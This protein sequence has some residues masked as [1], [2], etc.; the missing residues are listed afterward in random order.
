MKSVFH[1]FG[2]VDLMTLIIC[3]PI[4]SANLL[5][6][7]SIIFSWIYMPAIAALSIT[8]LAAIVIISSILFITR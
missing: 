2:I 4:I 3:L 6:V 5:A 7:L 8:V 1:G